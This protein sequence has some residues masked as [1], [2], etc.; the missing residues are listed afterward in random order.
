M[1]K[2]ILTVCAK[3]TNLEGLSKKLRKP[4]AFSLRSSAY[5]AV[6]KHL[7]QLHEFL[8]NHYVMY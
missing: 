7:L 5:S 6:E 4:W 2:F 1:V 8:I 3:D